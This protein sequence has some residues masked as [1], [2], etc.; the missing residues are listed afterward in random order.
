MAKIRLTKEFSFE[1]AHALYNYDGLCSN[2]HGHSYILSVTLIGEPV[3]DRSDPKCGM[4]VDFGDIKRWVKKTIVDEFDHSLLIS[5]YADA[6]EISASKQMFK[7]LKVMSFQP[8][9]EN[10]LIYIAEEIKKQ[11]P[12]HIHLHS[13]K[14]RETS[15]SF[16]EWYAEDN[17]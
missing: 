8:T 6:S 4:V 3:I 2:I 10:L 15:T 7:R 1:M 16:A 9:C 13:L 14:L 17:T 11:L 12:G 5:H